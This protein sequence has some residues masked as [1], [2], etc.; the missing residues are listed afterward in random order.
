[1][2]RFH[3]RDRDKPPAVRCLTA[4]SR[5][6]LIA[7]IEQNIQKFVA[8]LGGF[9]HAQRPRSESRIGCRSG[10]EQKP[11]VNRRS[12]LDMNSFWESSGLYGLAGDRHLLCKRRLWED[13][14]CQGKQ[15]TGKR[16][17]E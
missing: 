1:N 17:F 14:S 8:D 11:V 3:H 12:A 2:R 6:R 4:E 5:A 16:D 7:E 10:E 9:N 13:D 15:N